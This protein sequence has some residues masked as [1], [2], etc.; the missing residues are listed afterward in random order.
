MDGADDED[1][2]ETT[3]EDEHKLNVIVLGLDNT[4]RMH[5]LRSVQ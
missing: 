4:S 5:F 3:K 2:S 1:E